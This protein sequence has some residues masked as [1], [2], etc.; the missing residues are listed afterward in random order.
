MNFR[1]LNQKLKE[2]IPMDE[3]AQIN[4]TIEVN[5][6]DVVNKEGEINEKF[7]HFHWMYKKKIHFKFSNRIPKNITELRKLVKEKD[8]EKKISD[9]ELKNC[10][11]DL[12]VPYTT[13]EDGKK[14][15]ITTYEAALKLWNVLHKPYR[16]IENEWIIL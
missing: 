10:L 16:K 5:N 9:T 13:E 11:R 6:E 15:Q 14:I 4:G 8:S 12:K 3:M 2:L 1:E 7:A